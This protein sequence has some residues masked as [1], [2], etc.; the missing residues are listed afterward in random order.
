MFVIRAKNKVNRIPGED[1]QN[2]YTTDPE[3]CDYQNNIRYSHKLVK[4][5]GDFVLNFDVIDY[6]LKVL[7]FCERNFLGEFLRKW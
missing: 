3:G 2:G 6:L 7:L 5:R 1:Q 4:R